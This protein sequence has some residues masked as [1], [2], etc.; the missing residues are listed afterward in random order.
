MI[1]DRNIENIIEA[2]NG[3]EEAME[4]LVKENNGLIWSIVKRFNEPKV[5]DAI[6]QNINSSIY[7][8]L[9]NILFDLREITTFDID[10]AYIFAD[11]Y[12]ICAENGGKFVLVNPSL[13]VKE[14]LSNAYLEDII[15]Y[16]NSVEDAVAII[17]D[18]KVNS[19]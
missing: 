19:Q 8:G 15:P 17:A 3:N 16:S 1:Y 6:I 4:A 2:Q 5:F 14:A 9:K 10:N 18:Q 12:K 7:T 11:I 13:N